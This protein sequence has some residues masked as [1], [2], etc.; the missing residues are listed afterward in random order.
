M[1][2]EIMKRFFASIL[3]FLL[4]SVAL[5]PQVRE[6][7]LA[8]GDV[9]LINMAFN[10]S[11]RIILQ[12]EYAEI[13]LSTMWENLHTHWCWDKDGFFMNQA[14]HPY[15][16]SLY[17]NAGRSNGL[18]FWQSF[19]LSVAGSLMWEEFGETTAPAVNDFITTPI[20]GVV[21]GEPMHRLYLDAMEIVPF[22][23][24]AISPID[25]FNYAIRGKQT[26]VSGHTEEID[27]IFHGGHDFGCVDFSEDM[28]SENVNKL[29]VG[30]G[31]HIQYGIPAAHDTVEPFD[32]FTVDL[33]VGF[34]S[35]YY[36]VNLCTD[37]FLFS[38]AL[39]F[40]ES[41]ATLGINLMYEGKRS[42]ETT[43]SNAALGVKYYS[44][45]QF[46][47]SG[48][49]FKFYADLDGVFLGTRGLYRLQKNIKLRSG[50]KG[51]PTR[52][53]NFGAGPL[54]KAGFSAGNKKF[55]T[56]YAESEAS[57]LI[58]YIYSRLEESEANKHFLV[59]AK[60]GYE[61]AISEHFLLGLSDS[62]IFKK[63]WFV[64][65]ADTTQILNSLQIYGKLA[66]KR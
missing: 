54:S 32:L 48:T 7:A 20:C 55:G 11:A 52:Y 37:G 33:D 31:V 40:E 64:S 59:L 62:V 10:N 23:A 27:F 65:E 30:S 9:F 41:E 50:D 43:F 34:S 51:N 19:F 53:Y 18:G 15:Q 35:K 29:T 3:L 56:V 6:N 25:A 1:F 38:R 36:D 21:F 2:A 28:D 12:E 4:F 26:T 42:S 17:F 66:F 14:G 44:E 63:D 46:P 57:F 5:F 61:H 13:N 49:E 58:P 16:G 24:W 60:A 47:D 8:L 22:F 45:K 39:Y